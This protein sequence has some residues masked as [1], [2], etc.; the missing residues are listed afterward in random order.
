MRSCN[1]QYITIMMGMSIIKGTP[2]GVHP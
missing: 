2:A 1:L